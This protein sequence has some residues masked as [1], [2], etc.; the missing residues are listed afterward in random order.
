MARRP[1]PFT[2]HL[3]AGVSR[4]TCID[5]FRID[6]GGIAAN[7]VDATVPSPGKA[8]YNIRRRP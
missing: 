4:L 3:S 6:A 1:T 7:V 5:E 2:P 8:T